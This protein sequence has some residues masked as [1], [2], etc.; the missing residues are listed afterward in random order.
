MLAKAELEFRKF[1]YL[2][3][4]SCFPFLYGELVNTFDRS[5]MSKYETRVEGDYGIGLGSDDGRFKFSF[6]LFNFSKERKAGVFGPI[7]FSF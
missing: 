6:S 5:P 7:K 4:L 2:S 3:L 1:P